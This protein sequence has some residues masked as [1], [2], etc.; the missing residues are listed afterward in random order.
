MNCIQIISSFIKSKTEKQQIYWSQPQF[1]NDHRPTALTLELSALS[2]QLLSFPPS[3]LLFSSFCIP[4]SPFRIPK[5]NP[6]VFHHLTSVFRLLTSDTRLLL[7]ALCSLPH[8]FSQ[9]FIIF[10]FSLPPPLTATTGINDTFI[11]Q[12]VDCSAVLGFCKSLTFND[13]F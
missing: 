7:C 8:A 12:F 6:S 3:Q 4:Q 5:S 13:F 1:L 11:L 10:R 9:R 2:L